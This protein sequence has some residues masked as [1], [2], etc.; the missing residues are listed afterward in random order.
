MPNRG[1][2]NS[3]HGMLNQ[4]MSS[5]NNMGINNNNGMYKNNLEKHHMGSNAAHPSSTA[6]M[7]PTNQGMLGSHPNMSQGLNGHGISN[8]GSLNH[9][10]S[11]P[12]YMANTQS[13]LGAILQDN[14]IEMTGINQNSLMTHMNTLSNL[15]GYNP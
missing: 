1:H 2:P 9:N 13:Q 7:P 3:A 5:M 10:S 11:T 6:W 4:P 14:N 12:V 15:N 8:M